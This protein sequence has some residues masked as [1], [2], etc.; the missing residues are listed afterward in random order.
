MAGIGGAGPAQQGPDAGRELLGR[1]RLGE[2][3]VGAGLEPG[4]HVVGVGAGG[5]HDDRDVAG[6]AD[7]AAHLEAVDARAA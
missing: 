4:D 2:V 7:R 5:D 3:V 1:E 6:A